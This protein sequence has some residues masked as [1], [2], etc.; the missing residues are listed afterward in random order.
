MKFDKKKT[1]ISQPNIRKIQT[2]PKKWL[3]KANNTYK[4]P[5]PYKKQKI[6]GTKHLYSAP[7][8]KQQRIF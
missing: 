2:Q 3:R 4:K 5:K 8:Q 6:K 7:L 1:Q